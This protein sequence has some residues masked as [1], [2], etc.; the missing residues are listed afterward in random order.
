M[1][2]DANEFV[3]G[4]M[5]Y[6]KA[7]THLCVHQTTLERK[8]KNV[9]HNPDVDLKERLGRKNS[10]FTY[11]EEAEL[12]LWITGT[13]TKKMSVSA[14]RK[15][16]QETKFLRKAMFC[17]YRLGRRFLKE[18]P[19]PLFAVNLTNFQR[20]TVPNSKS[21]LINSKGRKHVGEFTSAETE[22]TIIV[23]NFFC[24]FGVYLSSML[25]FPR[26]RMKLQLIDGVPPGTLAVCHENG[27]M[28]SWLKKCVESTT[29]SKDII[30]THYNNIQFI[31]Y[32]WKNPLDVAFTKPLSIFS[33]SAAA[34]WL[35]H[36]ERVITNFQ[37][38]EIFESAFMKSST[39]ACAINGL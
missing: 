28:E 19:W 24:A 23:E 37:V 4:R 38:A 36:Q 21:K 22:T 18:T 2:D 7:T 15:E 5:G 29:T 1:R 32:A 11:S 8:V 3:S 6:Y 27:W 34:T 17:Q 35:S 16:S 20:T 14:C 26:Q 9:I 13:R 10:V 12:N 30:T 39:M 31:D 25:I 33:D